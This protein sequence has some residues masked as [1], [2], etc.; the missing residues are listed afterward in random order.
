MQGFRTISA[1]VT[2]LLLR[3][4]K[5]PTQRLLSLP[6]KRY[7]Q[8]KIHRLTWRKYYPETQKEADRNLVLK[9]LWLKTAF[10]LLQYSLISEGDRLQAVWENINKSRQ[11]LRDPGIN[12]SWLV[13]LKYL[14]IPYIAK[15]KQQ[16][17]NPTSFQE[18][19]RANLCLPAIA[20]PVSSE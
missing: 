7:H 5:K 1:T 15:Q 14:H 17:K 3:T 13:F 2:L 20:R 4:W 9:T 16:P 6:G 12:R 18:G 10:N 11:Y 8:L 19:Q